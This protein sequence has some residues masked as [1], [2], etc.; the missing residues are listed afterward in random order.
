MEMQGEEIGE[1]LRLFGIGDKDT[2]FQ[3]I[4]KHV[5]DGWIPSMPRLHQVHLGMASSEFRNKNSCTYGST[6]RTY[7]FSIA[8]PICLYGLVKNRHA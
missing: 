6:A 2:N 8:S 3:L 5:A 1:L 7:T 4:T